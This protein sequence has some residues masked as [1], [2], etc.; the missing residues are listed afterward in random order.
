MVQQP[1]GE[2]MEKNKRECNN[3]WAKKCTDLNLR[4][5]KEPTRKKN[6]CHNNS[7]ELTSGQ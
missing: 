2:A 5:K 3:W 4:E 6:N 7:L 1:A